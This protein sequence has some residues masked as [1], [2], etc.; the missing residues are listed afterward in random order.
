MTK[1][2]PFQYSD[3]IP[4]M[5][6]EARAANARGD[7]PGDHRP[8]VYKDGD[9]WVYRASAVAGCPRSLWYART[10]VERSPVAESLQKAFR[11]G[12]NS[13]DLALQMAREKFFLDITD[14]QYEYEIEVME[15]VVIR[16]HLD[17]LGKDGAMKREGNIE[18]KMLGK[19]LWKKSASERFKAIPHWLPQVQL[20]MRGS[21]RK[22]CWMIWGQKDDEGVCAEVTYSTVEYS[23]R[24]VAVI[25]AKVRE[26]EE[27]VASGKSPE[28][29]KEEFGCS[30]W[31]LH[32]GKR[33][34]D[35]LEVVTHEQ[36][37]Q[38]IQALEVCK[39][40]V[41]SAERK[42]EE[43]KAN[44]LELLKELG[45]DHSVRVEWKGTPMIAQHVVTERRNYAK[46]AMEQDGVLDKYS[47]LKTSDYWT[48]KPENPKDT[49]V[50]MAEKLEKK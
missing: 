25:L 11:E 31:Q 29:P 36:L 20:G 33:A 35:D 23:A 1:P 4:Q 41:K 39:S 44:V 49:M 5:Q 7:N 13:E 8:D 32:E 34:K 45:I 43:A 9:L 18:A 19:D 46:N 27:M 24:E 47:E 50:R 48:F 15:G 16:G 3:L 17:G 40:D 21:G 37:G 10:G 6:A 22:I 38:A 14:P 30:Y 28:C 12:S 26:I 2:E 42:V